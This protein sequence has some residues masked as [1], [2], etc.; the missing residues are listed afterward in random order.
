MTKNK[1][2]AARI[3][4]SQIRTLSVEAARAGDLRQEMICVLALSGPSALEGGDP[5]NDADMLLSAGRTREWA[6]GECARV[7]ADAAAQ[8]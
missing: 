6:R 5:G 4:D 3:T 7:I 8:E 1:T 2:T